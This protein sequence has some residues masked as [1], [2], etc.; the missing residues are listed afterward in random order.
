MG[1]LGSTRP[2]DHHSADLKELPTD[3]VTLLM[4]WSKPLGFVPPIAAPEGGFAFLGYQ[5]AS[6]SS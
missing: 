6:Q 2:A 4:V 3:M 1:D 5:A